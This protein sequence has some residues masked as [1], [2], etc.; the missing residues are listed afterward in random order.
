MITTINLESLVKWSKPK[1]VETRN[2]PRDLRTGYPGDEFWSAWRSDK[3]ALKDIG[4]SCGKDRNGNWEARW[5]KEIP[6]EE[7]EAVERAQEASRAT[8]ADVDVPVPEGLEYLPYQ[9]AGIAYALN[10]DSVLIGD[11]MGLGKTIQAIGVFNADETIK[12]V[13][14]VCPASLRLNWKREFEKWATR[15]VRTEIVNGGKASDFPSSDFDILIVNYDVLSK[16]RKRVDEIAWDMLIVDEAHYAKNQ[17]AQRTKAIFGWVTKDGK[18]K[19]TPIKARRKLFLTG[20]PIVNRPIEL[21]ILVQSLDPDGLGRNFFGFAKKYTNAYHN[22][23]GWD[24]SGAQNLDQLQR[25]MRERFMVRRLKADVL[26]ELPAK[27]RQVVEIPANGASKAVNE[28]KR[29]FDHHKSYLAELDERIREAE[30]ADAYDLSYDGYAVETLREMWRDA[31]LAAFTE[32]SKARHE[33]A[34][35]KVPHVVEHLETALEQGPVVCFAHH[36]D[37]VK[38]LADRFEGRVVTLTGETKMEDRQLAVDRFQNGEVDLFIGNIQA[39]GVGITLTRSSHVVFAELDWVP[40][41]LSQAEDRCHRIGQDQSVL[42]QHL[43]LEDSVD[44]QMAKTLVEK[45]EVI[46]KALDEDVDIDFGSSKDSV[47]IE[48]K[49]EKKDKVEEKAR[50]ITTEQKQAAHQG[51]KMLAGVCDGAMSEDGRGFNKMDTHFGKS[52][53][54][55][56]ELTDRQAVFAIRLVNKYRGQL[57]EEL[58]AMA[59]GEQK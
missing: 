30:T 47:D 31:M 56:D 17:S 24:F 10:R 46:S 26:K 36:K 14:V 43:V 28:E 20:T 34:L 9:K 27:R 49:P 12:K 11:E 6:S 52:L 19:Q 21:W 48:L 57:P 45:Q 2:G 33:V 3:D 7:K 1:R 51:L 58:V 55:K 44:A 5:W 35:A 18:V 50:T 54:M 32:M 40:G 16:H 39:A 15:T 23:Y 59:K 37:V 4:I 38:A 29:I 25:L 8:D 42:V 41:N 53:A 22:G 13:L